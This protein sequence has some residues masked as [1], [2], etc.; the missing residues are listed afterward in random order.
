VSKAAALVEGLPVHNFY[1]DEGD[2]ANEVPHEAPSPIVAK[3]NWPTW[4]SPS[5]ALQGH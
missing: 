5:G 4:D 1:T 3:R 2:I